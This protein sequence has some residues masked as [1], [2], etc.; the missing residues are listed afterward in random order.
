MIKPTNNIVVKI[1]KK[2]VLGTAFLL[3]LNIKDMLIHQ[4]QC[5]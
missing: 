5:D 1:V 4:I 2:A 3:Y